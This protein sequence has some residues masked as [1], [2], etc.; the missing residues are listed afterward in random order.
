MY[1]LTLP[2]QMCVLQHYVRSVCCTLI[3]FTV[4]CHAS[5]ICAIVVCLSVCEL[6]LSVIISNA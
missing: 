5:A 3:A 1:G 2:S 6:R 4:R